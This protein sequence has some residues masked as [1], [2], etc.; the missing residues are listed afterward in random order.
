M[1]LGK[2]VPFIDYTKNSDLAFAG[3]G[4]G[5]G[6]LVVTTGIDLGTLAYP[7]GSGNVAGATIGAWAD[8]TWTDIVN[9]TFTAEHFACLHCYSGVIGEKWNIASVYAHLND[10]G[11]TI[12][13]K[14]TID[15]EVVAEV[16]RVNTSTSYYWGIGFPF[17]G[18]GEY[19][20]NS[21]PIK[22]DSSYVLQGKR[23]GAITS[24]GIKYAYPLYFKA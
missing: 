17:S 15:G 6:D 5:L 18:E 4:S 19:S 11:S 14:L 12:G 8:D 2:G 20:A 9:V 13:L 10:A 3:V 16:T 7:L 1:Q 24:G 21:I 22:L 23:V